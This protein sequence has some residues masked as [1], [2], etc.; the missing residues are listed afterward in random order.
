LGW[1]GEILGSTDGGQTVI[2]IYYMRKKT[3]FNKRTQRRKKV[4]FFKKSKGM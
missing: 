1:G 2:R 3:I 4:Q